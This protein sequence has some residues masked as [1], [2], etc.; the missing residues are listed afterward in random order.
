M[1]VAHFFAVPL[2]PGWPD[3]SQRQ[4]SIEVG[5]FQHGNTVLL[6]YGVMR[7]DHGE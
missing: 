6:Y 1:L 4:P 5:Y 2:L 7:Y 3:R